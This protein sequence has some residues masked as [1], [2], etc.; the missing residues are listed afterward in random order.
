MKKLTHSNLQRDESSDE[1]SRKPVT[2]GK[3]VTKMY[4]T[5]AKFFD[6]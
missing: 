6:V 4:A 3:F 1:D 5:N 2:I